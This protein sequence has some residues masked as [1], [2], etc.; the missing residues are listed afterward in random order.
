MVE[1]G[2]LIDTSLCI[3]CRGCQVSCKQWNMM[4]AVVTENTGSYKNPP[5][6][7]YHTWTLVDFQE[8]RDTA[9]FVH[10]VFRKE[11]CRHCV[12]PGCRNACPVPNAVVKDGTGAVIINQN[13]CGDCNAECYDGCPWGIPRFRGYD[14]AA[15]DKARASWSHEAWKCWMCRDRI[16]EGRPTACS[17][18][19]APGATRTLTK[20]GLM[21]VALAR[22]EVLKSS[23]QNPYYPNAVLWPPAGYDT[24]VIWILTDSAEQFQ[25][26]APAQGAGKP[27]L[28]TKAMTGLEIG[29]ALASAG[30]VGGIALAAASKFVERVEKIKAEKANQ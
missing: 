10:W 11:Q 26:Q 17:Q 19:C 25:I 27:S 20:T 13:L 5:D 18:T 8:W 30:V 3:G 22:L 4:P 14:Y 21:S 2:M 9:G 16:S 6:L 12:D 1:Y 28:N 23:S 24:N 29:P 15:A 7:N